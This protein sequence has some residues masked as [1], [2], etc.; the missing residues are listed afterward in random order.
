MAAARMPGGA[1]RLTD[2][3]EAGPLRLR[4][5]RTA[6]GPLEAVL[7]NSAGGIACGDHFRVEADLAPGADLVLT[8]TAA[9]KIYRSDG[10]TTRL[11]VA[12]TVADGAALAWLPQETI[13]YD[14]VRLHRR[15]DAACAEGATLTVFEAM[16]FGRAARGEVL[17]HG[18]VRDDWRVTRGGRLVYAD[19]FRLDGPLSDHLSRPALAGGARASATLLHLAPDAESRLDAVRDLIEAAG[20]PDLAVEAGASAWNGFLVL[21]LLARDIR[22]LR[23][24]AIRILEGFRARPLPRVWQT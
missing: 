21:R 10:P 2:L 1:T 8:S 19:S 24:A 17:T 6:P 14:G 16:V 13:L 9:E 3:A 20:C 22:G 11:D 18:A 5:P 12:L 23:V 4:L 15:L 7:L